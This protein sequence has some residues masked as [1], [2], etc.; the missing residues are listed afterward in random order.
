MKP[1]IL[2]TAEE[3]PERQ[4]IVR[5]LARL[6][7]QTDCVDNGFLAV[8]ALRQK[9]YDLVL[10]DRDLEMVD[11]VET[12]HL[13]RQYHGKV[14]LPIIGMFPGARTPELM[15]CTMAGMND[16]ILKPVA[17]YKFKDILQRFLS[18]DEPVLRPAGLAQAVNS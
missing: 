10:L 14:D 5:M 8:D 1:Q 15:D 6:D 4:V 16:Y 2:L 11:I 3:S 12:T 17:V 18:A 13:I 9:P 7:C